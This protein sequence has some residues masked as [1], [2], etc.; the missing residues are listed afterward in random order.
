MIFYNYEL[1][2]KNYESLMGVAG[3]E[4]ESRRSGVRRDTYDRPESLCTLYNDSKLS[5]LNEEFYADYLRKNNILNKADFETRDCSDAVTFLPEAETYSVTDIFN[6]YNAWYGSGLKT[7]VYKAYKAETTFKVALTK[8]ENKPYEELQAMIGLTEAKE[9]VD[10][11]I[12]ASKVLKVRERMGLNTEGATLHMLFSGSP[13]TA[14]TSVARL[15]AKILKDEDVLKSGRFVECGRQDLV[16]KYVGWTAKIVEDK[17]REA[18]GGVLFID[19]AYSRV[20]DSNSYGAE[21]INT[22]IQLMENYRNEVI[23][24]F[25]GY[26]E[27][28]QVFLELNEGLK[29]CIAFHLNFPDYRADELLD[30]L[31]LMSEK[32]E[33]SIAE[34]ALKV[35]REFFEAALAEENFGNGRY[36][37]NLLEQ[38]ILRQSERVVRESAE[39]E[40]GRE[41][42]CLLKKEDFRSIPFERKKVNKMGFAI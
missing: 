16:G 22:I 2:W 39:R 34:D 25:A 31:K 12:A 42:L 27:K 33:Y 8:Q 15:L 38:A 9:V 3:R 30:I 35:C 19:E 6:A 1:R 24:I 20:D 7:H 11:I 28:M 21:A 29:S 36:V 23:V 17:F 10:Q 4:E 13:G 41:E 26:T 18:N 40:L 5:S 32:R 14:K 37:R